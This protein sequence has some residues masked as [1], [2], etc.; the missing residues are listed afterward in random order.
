[1]FLNAAHVF[2]KYI[3]TK[4]HYGFMKFILIRILQKID[5]NRIILYM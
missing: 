4:D 5:N 2:F 1:M 3:L